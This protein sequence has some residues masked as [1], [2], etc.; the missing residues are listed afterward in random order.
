MFS[1]SELKL[2]GL[3]QS[4]HRKREKERVREKE[5][6]SKR[7]T[8]REWLRIIRERKSFIESVRDRKRQRVSLTFC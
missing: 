3:L 1:L 8:G 4:T 7:K 5:T 2:C 6:E